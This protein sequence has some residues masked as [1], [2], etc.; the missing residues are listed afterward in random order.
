MYIL[1][2][3]C[4]LAV[5]C[6]TSCILAIFLLQMY[7]NKDLL[8]GSP[9]NTKSSLADLIAVCKSSLIIAVAS[10]I[11]FFCILLHLLL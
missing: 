5:F 9:K 6:F 10:F 1:L 4:S 8:G 7:M 3:R 2:K 11:L